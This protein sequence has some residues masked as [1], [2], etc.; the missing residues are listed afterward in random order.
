LRVTGGGVA[1]TRVFSTPRLETRGA[2]T[3]APR[4]HPVN[5]FNDGAPGTIV[6]SNAGNVRNPAWLYNLRAHPDVRFGG[7]AM[8]AAVVTGDAERDRLS[9]LADRVFPAFASYRRDA[10]KVHR[11]IPI[12][13]LTPTH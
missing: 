5:N 1:T 10:E 12:V 9:V 8:R 13:Q 6:A 11:T 7:I 3:R 2:Q 4:R